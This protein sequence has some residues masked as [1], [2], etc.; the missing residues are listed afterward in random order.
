MNKSEKTLYVLNQTFKRYRKHLIAL[1]VLGVMSAVLD[2]IGIN[3]V[4]PLFS[5]LIGNNTPPSLNFI[6]NA[7]Q[8]IFGFFGVPFTF[9]SLLIFITLLFLTRA[10]AIAVFTYIR[11]RITASFM[12]R[13]TSEMLSETLH[14]KWAFLAKQK[15]GYLQ[16]TLFWDVRQSTSLLD[17]VAQFIQSGTGF[18]IYFFVA[19]SISPTITIITL[20]IGAVLLFGLQPLVRKTMILGEEK[21]IFEKKFTNYL[22]EHIGGLKT[23]KAS[24]VGQKVIEVGRSS[25]EQLRVVY[26]KSAVMHSVGS[27]VI[28]PFSLVFILILFAFA[29]KLPS[30]DLA[31]FAAVLYL[32]QKIFIYLQSTQSTLHS[33]ADFIPFASNILKFKNALIEHKD[34]SIEDKKDPF[35]FKRNL[36]FRNVSFSYHTGTPVL[37]DISF[38]V[39][40]NSFLGIIGPSGG[41]KTSIVDLILRLFSPNKGEILLDD[42]SID[43]IKIDEWRRRIGYVS[44][45]IFLMNASIRDNI[46]FYDDSIT[47]EAIY[48]ATRKAHIYEHIVNMEHGL[49]TIVGDHGVSLSVGQRQRVVIARSL[50]RKPDILILDEA[51]S[52]LDSES[53]L[54]IKETIEGI[55]KTITLIVIAH[56]VS[57]ITNADNIIVVKDGSVIEKGSPKEMLSC[58]GSYLLRI[59][60]LQGSTYRQE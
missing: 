45:D 60:N 39:P 6:S 8:Q 12:F 27:T 55:R 26:V 56:R 23:V 14:A 31:A 47:D 59:V 21:S 33:V 38:S 46:K 51:T 43:K 16:N 36:S 52:A 22:T 3:A 58:S 2:G 25:L 11:A 37:T 7:I 5:F 28:Q 20:G 48:D 49:D 34:E 50:A 29:Y 53:E 42:V 40:K 54:A 32:I 9:R 1:A 57:T 4:I 13:E 18:I 15:G 30:F 17:T 10:V 19:L 35:I 41:G 44:Q 24:G